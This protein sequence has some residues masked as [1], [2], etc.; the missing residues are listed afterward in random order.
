MAIASKLAEFLE[1]HAPGHGGWTVF[2]KE[3]VQ[4]VLEEH[5]LPRDIAKFMPEDRISALEDMLEELLGLHPSATTLFRETTETILHLASLGNVIL[6]GHGSTV[7]TRSMPH[8]FHVRLVAPF[9]QRVEKVVRQDHLSHAD[10]VSLVKKE[11]AGRRHY[12]KD[13]FN[14]DVEDPML[15]H[16]V[17][18]L[19]RLPHDQAALLIGQAVLNWA[20]PQL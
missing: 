3:L 18:N 9:E 20:K 19:G 12:L 4:K 16:L 8:V 14:A 17:V 10:A 1:S 6:V 7:I 11:D 5:S 2:D 13:H 15:Y